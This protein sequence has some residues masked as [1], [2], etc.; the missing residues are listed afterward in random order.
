MNDQKE[1]SKND[2]K[3]HKINAILSFFFLQD[4]L[5]MW[6]GK[7]KKSNDAYERREPILLLFACMN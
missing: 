6:Q 3:N 7:E 5:A 1:V 4:Y 2:K